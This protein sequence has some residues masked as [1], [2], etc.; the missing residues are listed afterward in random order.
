MQVG[1]VTGEH[2]VDHVDRLFA[3]VNDLLARARAADAAVIY[4]QHVDVGGGGSAAFQL[5][6]A[7]SPPLPGELLI[8]KRAADA[9][10]ATPLHEELAARGIRPLVMSGCKTEFCIDTTCRLAT[11]LGYDVT[12]VHDAHSTT[13]NTVL[14]AERII[15]HH[16][17]LLDGFGVDEH[18]VVVRAS[19]AVTFP[20]TWRDHQM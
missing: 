2:A 6:P 13:A 20:A 16:N 17:C 15:A 8:Q 5:H 18:C 19:S 14:S 11:N 7:I 10:Y 3:R 12:L 9:F 1:L 4:V